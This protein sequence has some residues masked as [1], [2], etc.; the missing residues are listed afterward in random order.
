MLQR[1]IQARLTQWKKRPH[2]SLLL[3]G[4]RQVGKT[5]TCRQFGQE[6][7][8]HVVELNFIERPELASIFAG[9]L[10]VNDLLVNLSLYFPDIAIAPG[11]T[12]IFLDE[13]QQCPQAMTSLKFWTQDGR[14]DVI[15][16]GS[17]LG[18]AYKNRDFSFPVGNVELMYMYA[19]DFQEFLWAEGL[20]E[21]HM[22][23]LRS[24]FDQKKPVPM[25]FHQRMSQYL[26]TY[27]IVGG[28]PEVVQSFVDFHNLSMV[29]HLQQQI[30]QN[31]LFDIAHYASGTEKIKAEKCY[32]SIPMQLG[33]ENHK[34]QYGVVEH[35]GTAAKFGSSID[36]LKGSFLVRQ[37]NSLKRLELPPDLYTDENNFRL[38]MT[39][40]GLMIGTYQYE[41]K[42][43]LMEEKSLEEKSG[44]LI[45]GTA[46]G[47]LYEAL[48]ADFLIKQDIEKLYF[49]RDEKSTSEIEFLYLGKDGLVP[50]EIK[51]GKK[52]ANSLAR[53]LQSEQIPYGFKLSSQNVGVNGKLITL[54][55]YMMMFL[56]GLQ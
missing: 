42:R 3:L 2:K 56:T 6:S 54:P 36:W 38:Y 28:M 24:C 16:T 41:I 20:K 27:M 5:Y 9:S 30:Y 49:F 35:K 22:D 21:E 14:F 13:V 15:A 23:E 8:D 50:I 40:I 32:R 45:L 11:Q 19:L 39:D 48:A 34:F 10:Q 18:L 37:V 26:H 51:A 17:G 4:A 55:L 31:Y 43:A 29:H 33:K 7:Y 1:K 47:G 53:I 46:K 12:L 25:A 44:Q 52:R